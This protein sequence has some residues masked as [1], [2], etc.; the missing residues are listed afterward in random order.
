MVVAR[1]VVGGLGPGSWP[2]TRVAHPAHLPPV[3]GEPARSRLRH[4]S[5]CDPVVAS[6]H[7]RSQLHTAGTA[8]EAEGV[9]GGHIASSSLAARCDHSRADLRLAGQAARADATP[10]EPAPDPIG[11]V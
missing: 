3:L 6:E 11:S 8:F 4:D 9:G 5:R 2:G 7:T 10:V 1:L